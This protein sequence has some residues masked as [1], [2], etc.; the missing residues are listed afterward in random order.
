MKYTLS[1]FLS[2]S[3]AVL[4]T[5]DHKSDDIIRLP[6]LSANPWTITTSGCSSGGYMSQQMHII[7]SK[8]IK[9]SSSVGSGPYMMSKA[10]SW[11]EKEPK[12]TQ[13]AIG[14]CDKYE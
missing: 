6:E 8:H 2:L 14:Y 10:N 9:G 13:M 5:K 3:S 11:Y 7:F 4:V 12:L 1:I